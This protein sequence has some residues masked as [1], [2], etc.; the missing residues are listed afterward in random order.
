MSAPRIVLVH[1]PW[2]VH[3]ASAPS[4]ASIAGTFRKLKDAAA[5]R[6]DALTPA[7]CAMVNALE[8][9]CWSDVDEVESKPPEFRDSGFPFIHVRTPDG[10]HT[11]NGGD[12]KRVFLDDFYQDKFGLHWTPQL[13]RCLARD[14]DGESIA[15]FQGL[16]LT[17]A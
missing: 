2:C 12:Q 13:L 11:Y 3:C 6:D 9:A 7:E 1:A 15:R 4:M 17:S 14:I 8:L 10:T 16:R 5:A